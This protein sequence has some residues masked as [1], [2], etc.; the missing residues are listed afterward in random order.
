[1]SDMLQL[2]MTWLKD[3]IDLFLRSESLLINLSRNLPKAKE[4]LAKVFT[5]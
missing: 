5:P 4:A 1:M 2:D 3:P